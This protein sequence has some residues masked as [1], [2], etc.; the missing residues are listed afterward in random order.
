MSRVVSE[1]ND[2]VVEHVDLGF[3]GARTTIMTISGEDGSVTLGDLTVSAAGEVSIAGASITGGAITDDTTLTGG[4]DLIAGAGDGAFDFSLATGVFKTSTGTNTL[5][6][7]VAIAG[8]KTFTTGTG[9]VALNGDV[10]LAA[11]KDFTVTAGDSAFDASLGTGIFK[12]TTGVNTLGG[13]VVIAGAK[14]FTTGTGLSTFSGPVAAGA[15]AWAITDPGDAGAIPV[16][17]SGVCNLTSGVSGETRTVAAPTFVGQTL[18]LCV[19]VD[20]GGDIAVDFAGDIDD[21]GNDI[22]TAGDAG[23]TVHVIGV[24]IGGSLRWR[25]LV[26]L[27][28]ALS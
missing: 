19:D 13:N 1:G 12:T 9:A 17:S 2:F 23:D 8:A 28:G 5:G 14:T 15:T 21:S 20:G 4:K 3:G 22:W 11:G 18:T 16:T 10:T 24:H 26:N 25:L 27:G 7:N 6:G